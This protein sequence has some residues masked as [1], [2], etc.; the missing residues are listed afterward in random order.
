MK[1][2]IYIIAVIVIVCLILWRKSIVNKRGKGQKSIDT[3]SKAKNYSKKE[4]LHKMSET[5]TNEETF[6]KNAPEV[7]EK[8]SYDGS[9]KKT[10]ARKEEKRKSQ[11]K[12]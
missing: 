8:E 10:E 6:F 1:D 7:K 2:K 3:S 4:D 11:I 5:R 12:K 9:R